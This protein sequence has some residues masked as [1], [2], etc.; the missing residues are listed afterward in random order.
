MS[1]LWEVDLTALAAGHYEEA[2]VYVTHLTDPELGDNRDVML[3]PEA[4]VQNGRPAYLCLHRPARADKYGSRFDGLRPSIFVATARRLKDF[5]TALAGH[6][7]LAR[8]EL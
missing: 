8:P 6:E 3:F 2:F 1:V 4:V 7:L 5:P